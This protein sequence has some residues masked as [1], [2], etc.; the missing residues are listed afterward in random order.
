[1][2]RTFTLGGISGIDKHNLMLY[3]Y[4]DDDCEV[5]INGV[6]AADAI[7][8]TAGYAILPISQA[9]IDALV[10]DGENTIAIYC[11]QNRGG[12]Y[13]DAGISLA[14]FD[15]PVPGTPGNK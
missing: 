2:R 5:Y 9:A 14:S 3:I 12:Q 6:K 1:M 11:K 13:I 8:H 10:P 15:K 4:H 7:S